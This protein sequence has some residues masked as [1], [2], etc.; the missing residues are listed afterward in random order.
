VSPLAKV[1]YYAYGTLRFG[2]NVASGDSDGD[3]YD[4]LITG[5]G[6]GAV[7]GPHVRGFDYDGASVRPQPG[8]SFYA[9]GTPL[10]VN[11][12]RRHRRRP[13]ARSHRRGGVR[14]SA[15]TSAF[16][17]DGAAGVTGQLLRLRHRAGVTCP[18]ATSTATG[19][20]IT[21]P[22]PGA[23]SAPTRGFD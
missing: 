21:G 13:S 18:A 4:E 6:P 22:G 5:A 2:V 12:G 17:H 20:R 16:D 8:V 1:S 10:G 7:F 14:S 11:G 15:P 9:Y 3:G 19:S 23:S